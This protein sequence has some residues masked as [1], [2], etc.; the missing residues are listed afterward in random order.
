MARADAKTACSKCNISVSGS[1]QQ[2]EKNYHAES[3][4]VSYTAEGSE[5]ATTLRLERNE[6]TG[7]FEC[8]FC[9]KT[10]I[11]CS[12]ARS[13]FYRH[14]GDCNNSDGDLSSTGES[15]I[16]DSTIAAIK[17][18]PTELNTVFPEPASHPQRG[19]DESI[20]RALRQSGSSPSERNKALWIVDSLKLQ[21]FALV[22]NNSQVE[23]I[24]LT[25]SDN[26]TP[27]ITNSQDQP[28]RIKNISTGK[29][30]TWD[31][32]DTSPTADSSIEANLMSILHYGPYAQQLSKRCYKQLDMDA[33]QLLNDDWT[34]MPQL[35]YAC[36][37]LLAGA[38]I[39][40][41]NNEAI[42]INTVEIYGRQRSLD[43]H[44]ERFINKKGKSASSS[45]P[46]V[47]TKYHYTW[48]SV[49]NDK[50]GEKLVVGT[51]TLNA[52]VTSSLRIDSV[53]EASVGGLISHFELDKSAALT[54]SIFLDSDSIKKANSLASNQD[55]NKIDRFDLRYQLRQL[56][57]KFHYPST[58]L[59]CRASSVFANDLRSQPYSIYT[60][61]EAPDTG[62]ESTARIASKLFLTIAETVQSSTHPTLPKTF[63][64]TLL[65]KCQDGR[66]KSSLQQI[67]EQY[68]K[69]EDNLDILGNH[70]LNEKLKSLANL[71][72]PSLVSAN[73]SVAEN[74]KSRFLYGH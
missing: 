72:S 33:C 35:R 43:V 3:M 49:V 10:W 2:H 32:R 46:P 12:S 68:K 16:E 59:L 48:A 66:M 19:F 51:K 4:T 73:K 62:R 5:T 37:Q 54:A 60:L 7:Q 50:E 26:L 20:L 28:V 29:K 63:V 23:E 31:E 58:Y 30:R 34:F 55:T 22:N 1:L 36:A 14:T 8:P 40:N 15:D 21:P 18:K 45:L 74:V 47:A 56:R 71:M 6:E 27:F 38:I 69:N 39:I 11:T 25:H 53:H 24:A 65:T 67:L 13:H 42:L 70:L 64:N 52:L 44:R 41:K 9:N 61:Y 17:M 57:S